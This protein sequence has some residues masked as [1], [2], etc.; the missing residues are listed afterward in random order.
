MLQK[1]KCFSILSSIINIGK[2]PYIDIPLAHIRDP[3]SASV[4]ELL[5]GRVKVSLR[6]VLKNNYQCLLNP[7]YRFASRLWATRYLNIP[8]LV[9]ERRNTLIS[10]ELMAKWT[11]IERTGVPPRSKTHCKYFIRHIASEG[12]KRGLLEARRSIDAPFWTFCIW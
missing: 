4:G 9:E 8:G 1:K 12:S 3:R 11:C 2:S 10:D 5:Y 7:M 6:I